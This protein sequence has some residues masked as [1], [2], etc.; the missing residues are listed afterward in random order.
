MLAK[1]TAPPDRAAPG[2]RVPAAWRETTIGAAVD[3]VSAAASLA[4]A[5]L[6]W[7]GID[8]PTVT[9]GLDPTR[10]AVS[11]AAVGLAAAGEAAGPGATRRRR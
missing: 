5:A 7:T 1:D 10:W 2:G 9:I 11:A 8:G 4:C 3:G 6:R